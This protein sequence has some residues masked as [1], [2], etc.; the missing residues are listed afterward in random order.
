MSFV[1]L[2][3][4]C[5]IIFRYSLPIFLFSE[6]TEVQNDATYD[7]MLLDDPELTS[8]KHR[9]VLNLKSYMV[10]CSLEFSARFLFCYTQIPTGNKIISKRPWQNDQTLFV[11]YLKFTYEEKCFY[12][13]ATSMNTA[14]QSFL[15]ASK[16][17]F[18][19]NNIA[20]QNH[21]VQYGSV[22]A[23]YFIQFVTKYYR[24]PFLNF[25]RFQSYNMRSHQKLKKTLT[26]DS[27]RSFPTLTSHWPNY[28]GKKSLL[29]KF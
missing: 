12:R 25:G 11:K 21:R 27:K 14:R 26:K 24:K 6:T 28:G 5:S 10:G 7:P 29:G 9:T 3:F 18:W 15:P 1:F 20:Q 23:G 22:F 19:S 2:S 16:F 17:W 4:H 8:G 13:L